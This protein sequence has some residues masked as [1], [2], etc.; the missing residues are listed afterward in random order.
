MAEIKKN[1]ELLNEEEARIAEEK[2]KKEKQRK[3]LLEKVNFEIPIDVSNPDE[4]QKLICVNGKNFI[5]QLG[6]KVKIPRYVY[7]AYQ[8]AKKQEMKAI[9]KERGLLGKMKSE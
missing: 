7:L 2:A 9:K 3:Y 8:D 1:D 4:T 6:K 5:I